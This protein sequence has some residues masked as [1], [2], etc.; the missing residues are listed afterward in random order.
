MPNDVEA[1]LEILRAQNQP[2]ARS[3]EKKTRAYP[4]VPIYPCLPSLRNSI[5][6][7]YRSS[8]SSIDFLSFSVLI[9]LKMQALRLAR[10]AT[11]RP[12]LAQAAQRRCLATATASHVDVG[13]SSASSASSGPVAPIPVSNIEAQWERLS[14]EEKLSVHEQLEVLQQKDWTQLSLD[15]KK[16]GK[17]LGF[18][19]T[20]S[21]AG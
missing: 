11:L 15:E 3:Y 18:S 19:K 13:S 1:R 4:E 16:A 6:Y 17:F 2:D 12:A 20:S 7:L 14:S 9:H 10:T 5:H 8:P 21:F